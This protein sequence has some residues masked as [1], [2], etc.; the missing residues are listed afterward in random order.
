MSRVL[1]E[2]VSKPL[3]QLRQ[4]LD[5]VIWHVRLRRGFHSLTHVET[6]N[7]PCCTLLLQRIIFF[8]SH[9]ILSKI[10]ST[11]LCLLC[12]NTISIKSFTNSCKTP[13]VECIFLNIIKFSQQCSWPH[14]VL[15]TSA[16][17]QDFPCSRNVHFAS[18]T[19]LWNCLTTPQYF[20]ITVAVP[21]VQILESCI[22]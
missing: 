13:G 20:L 7:R 4:M 2:V 9:S 21:S 10:K 6:S 18:G 12:I 3:T 14:A 22:D 15:V 11:L 16:L 8:L 19:F 17:L 1:G 5:Y